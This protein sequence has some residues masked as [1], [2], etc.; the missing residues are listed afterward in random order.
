[1]NADHDT[2]DTLMLDEEQLLAHI[3][4]DI[5]PCAN[6]DAEIN[7]DDS[8]RWVNRLVCAD[9]IAEYDGLTADDEDNYD[10]EYEEDEY[11]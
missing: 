10:S 8:H 4:N 5:I 1:M 6:C 2:T 7:V 9:C 3:E 11:E